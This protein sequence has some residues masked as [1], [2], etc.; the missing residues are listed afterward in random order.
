[1]NW[2]G[3]SDRRSRFFPVNIR[4]LAYCLSVIVTMCRLPFPGHAAL[5][6]GNMGF[7]R[8]P[9]F[10]K[11]QIDRKLRHLEP[12]VEQEFAELGRCLPLRLGAH[13]QVE[14]RIKPGHPI[15]A[16]SR[17][18]Q[19]RGFA[20][21]ERQRPARQFELPRL[22]G[23][24]AGGGEREALEAQAHRADAA[25][26]AHVCGEHLRQTRLGFLV[27]IRKAGLRKVR[28]QK[29]RHGPERLHQ[30][31][32]ERKSVAALTVGEAERGM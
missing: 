16:E 12:L 13:R 26:P 1:M 25:R 15:S 14:H 27:H 17:T 8:F 31:V 7:R 5:T 24:A 18:L 28:Y 4:A 2:S 21:F 22:A 10:G 32:G 3:I 6:L 30:V 19:G 9:A 20:L 11:A 23:E 29:V